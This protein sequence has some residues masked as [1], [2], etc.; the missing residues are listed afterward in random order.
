[1]STK[2]GS[3]IRRSVFSAIEVPVD[4]PVVLRRRILVSWSTPRAVPLKTA[5]GHESEGLRDEDAVEAV[6]DRAFLSA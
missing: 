2:N 1:M 4:L 5:A 6:V 3:V